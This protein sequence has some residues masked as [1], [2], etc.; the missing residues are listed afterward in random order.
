MAALMP[1]FPRPPEGQGQDEIKVTDPSRCRTVSMEADWGFQCD[2]ASFFKVVARFNQVIAEECI[3]VQSSK[4]GEVSKAFTQD[5]GTHKTDLSP[6]L[7]SLALAAEAD[8]SGA[9]GGRKRKDKD[10]DIP[11]AQANGAKRERKK[12]LPLQHDL[13]V[14]GP[15]DDPLEQVAKAVAAPRGNILHDKVDDFDIYS[16]FAP[17]D[18]PPS[19]REEKLGAQGPNGIEAMRKNDDGKER[20]KWSKIVRLCGIAGCTYK[21]GQTTTMKRHKVAKHGIEAVW[22]ND[23]GKER[24][25]LGRI[26]KVCGIA[27]CTYK[28]GTTH[29]KRH[30]ASKHGI[31]M[32]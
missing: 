16:S 30:K 19:F 27:G 5:R 10:T 12:D 13:F 8:G 18:S 22:K 26:I 21:T 17:I 29:M 4:E 31:E 3:L 14:Q 24:D 23:D 15:K 25:K 28:T 7:N 1:I 20:D 6:A 32:V 9:A 2:I 11:T